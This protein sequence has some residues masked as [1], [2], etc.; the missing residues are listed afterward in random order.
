[1]EEE[2]SIMKLTRILYLKQGRSRIHTAAA[3]ENHA[4]TELP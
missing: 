4:P 2:G 3:I 1:M